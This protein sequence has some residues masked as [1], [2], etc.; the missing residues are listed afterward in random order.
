MKKIILSLVAVLCSA[1]TM[2]QTSDND[3]TQ[4]TRGGDYNCSGVTVNGSTATVTLCESDYT[5]IIIQEIPLSFNVTLPSGLYYNI[6]G[7]AKMDQGL[8]H[9]DSMII[10]ELDAYGDTIAKLGK[11]TANENYGENVQIPSTSSSGRFIFDIYCRNGATSSTSGF[12]FTVSPT[13][14]TTMGFACASYMG[15]GTCDPQKTLHVNGELMVSNPQSSSARL[16]V[17][18]TGNAINF[19][20]FSKPFYFDHKVTSNYGFY[21]PNNYNLTLGTY[22]TP[23]MTILN[24]NG[25]VGIGTTTPFYKLD[26]AGEIR[27]D[28][29][30]NIAVYSDSVIVGRIRSDSV[31]T[32]RI[33]TDSIAA[34]VFRSDSILTTRIVVQTFSGADFVFDKDYKL[35]ELNDV[36]AFVEANGHLPEIQSAENM[37]RDGVNV[38]DFQIQLLRKIEELTL[39]IIKQ[40]ERIKELESRIEK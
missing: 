40:E 4:P 1:V 12:S 6:S 26:V 31:L 22:N 37:I 27:S 5:P 32:G 19:L 20:S 8:Q 30:R 39:Y 28:S 2:A 35:P 34:R 18:P 10:W 15:V 11:F 14:P 16:T 13:N 24:S 21:S 17:Q 7:S 9:A 33:Y 23:R 36:K 38:S 25:N 3:T 29:I